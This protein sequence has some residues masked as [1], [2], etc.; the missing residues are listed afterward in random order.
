MYSY[1]YVQVTVLAE[2]TKKRCWL[3]DEKAV[4]QFNFFW[5]SYTNQFLLTN[6]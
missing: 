5:F 1:N 2:L 3:N 6:Q 4:S